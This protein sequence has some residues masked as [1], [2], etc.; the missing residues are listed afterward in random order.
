MSA[1]HRDKQYAQA[2]EYYAKEGFFGR[3]WR[4]AEELLR[5][6][7]Q[8]NVADAVH[9]EALNTL[10]VMYS[11][12][13]NGIARDDIKAVTLIRQA[14][15]AGSMQALLN[16]AEMYATG[17]GVLKDVTEAQ[18]LYLSAIEAGSEEAAKRLRRL[19]T[20]ER[21]K[22]AGKTA[23]GIIGLVAAGTTLAGKLAG[24]SSG[25]SRQ[26]PDEE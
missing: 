17:Q 12:G 1:E 23:V 10:G 3:K 21:L 18:R 4:K 19:Q 25:H 5:R 20:T 6:I 24:M 7:I 16:L 13:G 15:N 2:Y 14:A 9:A 11:T 8:A 22:K 26:P